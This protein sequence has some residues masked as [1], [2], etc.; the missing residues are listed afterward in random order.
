MFR[1]CVQSYKIYTEPPPPA[2]PKYKDATPIAAE[3]P[4]AHPLMPIQGNSTLRRACQRRK[5]PVLELNI[6]KCHHTFWD[7]LWHI[8]C[9]QTHRNLKLRTWR[10]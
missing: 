5:S 2:K 3:W 7:C 9:W 10:L 4:L 8:F 1:S 6:F